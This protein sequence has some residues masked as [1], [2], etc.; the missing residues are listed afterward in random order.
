MALS[1]EQRLWLQLA[2]ET[3]GRRG[4][5]FREDWTF[6]L[7][8]GHDGLGAPLA[9]SL[10]GSQALVIGAAR[11]ILQPFARD[12]LFYAFPQF[13]RVQR[14][15]AQIAQIDAATPTASLG[16]QLLGRAFRRSIDASQ[17]TIAGART[18][19]PEWTFHQLA[20][21][22]GLGMALTP[23]YTIQRGRVAL[24]IFAGDTL[25]S[26]TP[27]FADVERL[28]AIAAADPLF[29]ELW[30]QTYR[31]AGAVYDP[32]SPFQR[33]GLRLKLGTPLSD[34]YQ[35]SFEGT[36]VTLQIFA[37][38]TLYSFTSG[39][40]AR[41]SALPPPDS[42][43]RFVPATAPPPVPTTELIPGTGLISLWLAENS[44]A[45]DNV[46]ALIA[47]A[48]H[49][50]GTDAAALTTLT[51]QQR[52]QLR[53]TQDIVCADLVAIA[54]RA[55]GL[56]LSWTVDQPPGTL[57][58]ENR[59]ANYYRPA[60]GRLRPLDAGEVLRPGDLFL[61]KGPMFPAPPSWRA[62]EYH[63]V[64]IY[65]GPYAGE[66]GSGRA[67]DQSK[68]Y[69]VVSASIGSEWIQGYDVTRARTASFLG[70]TTVDI[71]R[72]LGLLS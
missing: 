25:F 14:L 56:E 53:G 27:P 8:A 60:P 33:E 52:E 55:G 31:V 67:Y 48:L 39:P 16:Y 65:V 15:S 24:Q 38:D 13:S 29:D 23:N 42:V 6:H 7:Q 5:G 63:H 26:R 47:T 4:E 57:F 72:P 58:A 64:L 44:S 35:I 59:A 68:G 37:Y 46:R 1:F 70:Y 40:I 18:L 54:L 41:W 2:R 20:L 11:Y 69:C 61:Y 3:Y 10:P 49:M 50:L 45:P 62:G 36:P 9:R 19:H 17:T 51:P 32:A 28:S 71:V 12:V 43:Q 66:D 22:Q 34:S 30:R 21:R